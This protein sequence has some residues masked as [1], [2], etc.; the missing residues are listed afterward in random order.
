MSLFQ[1]EHCGCAENTALACQ[2]IGKF[3]AKWFDWTGIED[4]EGKMLCSECAPT[5]YKDG[6]TT[7]LGYWHFEFPKVLL[8]K[9]QFKTNSEGN[10]EHTETG[11]TDFYKYAITVNYKGKNNEQH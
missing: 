11:D 9:G 6:T 4:R 5:K 2:G 3:A 7:G 8:P 10:L 1:C